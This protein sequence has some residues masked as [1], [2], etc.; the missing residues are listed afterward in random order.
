MNTRFLNARIVPFSGTEQLLEG[1]LHVSGDT[2]AYVGAPKDTGMRFDREIDC[3]GGVL[4]PGFK[5]A[6]THSAMTF[7]RSFADD[8]PL[9]RWLNEMC[10]PYERQLTRDDVLVLT[11]LAILE[12]LTSGV[13]MLFDMYYHLDAIAEAAVSTGFRAV[14]MGA[15]NDFGGTAQEM[16]DEYDRINKLGPL[17][18]YKLGCHAEYTTSLPLLK[19]LAS[20]VQTVR[21]PFYTHL[22]ET[23]D[24]VEGCIGR[25]GKRPFELLDS[26]GMFNFG[27]GGF[28]CVHVSE[29]E[30][31]IMK[32]RGL[33]A[34]TC[35]A[36]NLKLASG[37]APVY[38]YLERGIPVAIGTDGPA[39]NN[40]LD[41][42]REMFLVTGLQK[43]R[44]G[45][46]AVDAVEVLKMACVNGADAVGLTDCNALAPGKKADLTLIS[47]DWPN[48][49]PVNNAVKNIVYSG[50]K[51][52]VRLTMIAGRI[53]Y[54]NGEFF[55]GEDAEKI[56]ADAGK[57]LKRM[58]K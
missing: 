40:C 51:Q 49:Q 13:T 42:F 29:H 34:V 15:A 19:D 9:A 21:Q 5:N 26:L 8:L 45:A 22:C 48:M 33:Y 50:S 35:P 53:L 36:S 16:L 32:A 41:M 37:I 4:L 7:L 3:R 55:V 25:Y 23:A 54:E 14:I 47:L 18:C 46:D 27:G 30:M 17:V 28:H 39:S 44:H 56:Y 11:K 58:L 24:E 1:E 12:Y 6:H 43:Y 31:E 10:F 38:E 52:N 20:A 2:I 57:V